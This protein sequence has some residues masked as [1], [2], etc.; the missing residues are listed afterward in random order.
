MKVIRIRQM[1]EL[2]SVSRTTLWRWERSGGF[3]ERRQL[4]PGTVGYFEEDVMNW[5]ATRPSL[6]P[7]DEKT[8]S[9]TLPQSQPLISP[10]TATVTKAPPEEHAPK[11]APATV[12]RAI[13]SQRSHASSGGG[14]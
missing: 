13:L 14:A 3:V 6:H 9:P 7:K 4:G 12:T 5:L 1:C 11:G 8:V 2:L 10:M